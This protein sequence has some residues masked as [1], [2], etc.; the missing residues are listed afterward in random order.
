MKSLQRHIQESFK[1]NRDAPQY[2]SLFD[3]DALSKIIY[4]DWSYHKDGSM[5]N[6]VFI[7]RYRN[8]DLFDIF[9]SQLMNGAKEIS[10]KEFETLA[11]KNECILAINDKTRKIAIFVDCLKKDNSCFIIGNSTS[12]ANGEAFAIE[13]LADFP[14]NFVWPFK[15]GYSADENIIYYEIPAGYIDDINHIFNTIVNKDEEQ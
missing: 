12:Y 4:R 11:E 15:R 1:I 13:Y 8:E 7:S 2:K 9:K 10:R 14:P 3:K 6:V 5:K